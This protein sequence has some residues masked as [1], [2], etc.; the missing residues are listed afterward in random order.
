MRITIMAA[1]TAIGTLAGPLYA[2][3]VIKPTQV[4]LMP[5]QTPIGPPQSEHGCLRTD[6]AASTAQMKQAMADAKKTGGTVEELEEVQKEVAGCVYYKVTL[7]SKMTVEDMQNAGITS[8]IAGQGSITFGLAP[9]NSGAGY[10]F[11]SGEQDLAAPF[12]WNRGSALITRPGC[13]VTTVELPYTPFEFWLGVTNSPVL[14]VGVRISPADQDLHNIATRCKDP[15]DRWIDLPPMQEAIFAPAWIR[16]HGEGKLAAPQTADQKALI[17]YTNEMGPGKSPAP[18][19]VSSPTGDAIDMQKL[20]AMDPEKL[21]A[22][23]ANL[24]PSKAGDRA[25]LMDLMKDVK[26]VVPNADKQMAAAMDNFMFFAPGDCSPVNA[27]KI[28]CSLP[29]APKTMPDRLGYGTIKR[30]TEATTITIEKVG[31]PRGRP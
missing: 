23:A 29:S 12:Y 3:Q 1:V 20:M 24:D 22:M 13:I 31:T 4:Q 27:G 28:V 15:L 5:P 6:V 11:T 26:G 18:P 8:T 7:V 21:A 25:T 17:K 2:R 30:I 16:M 14:K 10:D 19:K 9:D